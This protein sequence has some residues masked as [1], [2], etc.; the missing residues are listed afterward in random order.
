MKAALTTAAASAAAAPDAAGAPLA[1]DVRR[2]VK[3]FGGVAA[4]RGASLAVTRGTVHGLIGQNGAGKST[5]VKLLAGLHAPDEGEITVGGV[6]FASGGGGSRAP[7]GAARRHST[8]IGFIHQERLLPATFTVAEALFFPHPPTLGGRASRLARLL[9]LDVKRMRRDCRAVLHTQF[10][11]DLAPDRLIG[12]LSVAEQQIVQ[13]TRALLGRHEILV[14]DEPSAALVSSEVDRLLRTI[15]RLRANGHTILY[16]SHYLDEIARVC[17]RVSV[18][19]DGADVAHF[20]ARAVSRDTLVAA[21]IGAPQPAAAAPSAATARA[22]ARADARVSARADAW[23]D[24]AHRAPAGADPARPGARAAPGAIALEARDLALP[25]RFGPLSLAVRRG[26]I[27]GLTGGLGSGGKDVIRALFGLARG[28]RGSIAVDGRPARV[29]RPHDAVAHG[30]ALVPENRAAHGVALTLP[31]RENVVLADLSSVSR[32]GLVHGRREADV[33]RALI[34]RLDIRPAR[35]D[36]PARFLSGGNQQKVALA[37]WLG[38]ASTVYLLD[39]PTVGVDVGAKAQIYRLIDA[40]ARA[41]AAV[42]LFSSDLT[43]LLD[44]T[45]RVYVMARGEIVAQCASAETTTRDVL[46]WAT[47]ARDARAAARRSPETA[48][49]PVAPP[50]ARGWTPARRVLLRGGPWLA[51]ALVFAGFSVSSPLFVTFANLGNVL[52]QS[53]VTGLLAFGLTIVMIGGGADAIKG[54][55]DLSIAANLG[56]CAAVFAALTRDGH[57]DALTLAATCATGVAVGAL[58]AWAVAWLRIPPLLATLATM[59]VCAGLELVL[60]ENAPISSPSPLAAA[61]VGTGPFGAP[62][63]AYALVGVAAALAALA[64]RTRYGLALHALGAHRAAALAAGVDARRY[65]ASSYVAS[66][67]SAAL[68]ALASCALLSGSAPGAGD[69]LLPVVAAVLLGVVFSRRLVP[70]IP[71]TLVAVL[72]VGL[73]ANGFQLNS[74][75][76]YWVSGVEGALILFVVAAV[77]LLRRRRSQGAFDA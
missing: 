2:V 34:R 17:D 59:N 1:L 8:G 43:E 15:E 29:R 55:L 53:A 52:Q 28:V 75:S 44:V 46:A 49:A 9:P 6:P 69:Y 24:D 5:L 7:A 32:F 51:L 19:R 33:A 30:I 10:G 42:L 54:G 66:G 4:L 39:E 70:T 37:K 27:V 13:I 25:G 16:V 11:L 68:A 58:N 64:H 57:G 41:G 12:E 48:G 62:W 20:E 60:T 31:V 3:R 18:L 56:L 14:F 71:G 22:A 35:P 67:L 21:M 45:D 38:R 65:V 36:L 73:L 63:L 40:L 47:L 76:S 77:A 26:E 50:G 74:V 72:F 23:G 61:L